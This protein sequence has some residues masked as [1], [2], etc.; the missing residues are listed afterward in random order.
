MAN[1]FSNRNRYTQFTPLKSWL[2]TENVGVPC[3]E[4]CLHNPTE[5]L[6][7]NKMSGQEGRC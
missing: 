2:R 4:Q 5:N 1:G 6:G 3:S 7:A